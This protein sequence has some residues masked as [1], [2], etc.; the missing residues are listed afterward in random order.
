MD[1][2]S[3]VQD[4]HATIH[5]PRGDVTRRAQ[6]GGCIDLPGKEENNRLLSGWWAG[7]DGTTGSRGGGRERVLKR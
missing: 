5:K 1:V 2:H 4:N 6:R 3:K 7:G